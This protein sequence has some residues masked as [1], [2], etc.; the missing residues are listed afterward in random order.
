M[1]VNMSDYQEKTIA[2][3]ASRIESLE[4][5]LEQVKKGR[6]EWKAA[7][8]SMS[9]D[10]Q[11]VHDWTKDGFTICTSCEHQDSTEEF[12]MV[13]LA[14]EAIEKGPVISLAEIEAKAILGFLQEEAPKLEEVGSNYHCERAIFL[15][16]ERI[17]AKAIDLL[18][19]AK[20]SN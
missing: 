20:E 5:E 4:A 2:Y 3:Q 11:C 10:M 14:K 16:R 18:T 6:D 1:C 17:H 19:Q 12:D 15:D 8:W 9:S 13:W 7:A